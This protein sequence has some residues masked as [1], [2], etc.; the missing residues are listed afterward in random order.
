MFSINIKYKD[1]LGKDKEHKYY[2]HMRKEEL[3]AKDLKSFSILRKKSK[4]TDEELSKLK[5][6][7]ALAAYLKELQN[8][9]DPDEMYEFFRN[10]MLEAVG[11]P[12][13]DGESFIKTDK[14]RTKFECSE[15]LF[16][17][18]QE[19]LITPAKGVNFIIGILPQDMQDAI[20]TKYDV[21]ELSNGV[22][23]PVENK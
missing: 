15:A 20:K 17:L 3:F 4:M 2:F 16:S 14:T 12:G 23:K 11:E 19:L 10:L 21:S 8:V 22:L 7:E 6:G 13:E 9:K 5:P 1:L 18:V